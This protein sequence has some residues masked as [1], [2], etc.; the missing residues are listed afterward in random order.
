MAFK[1]NSKVD[2]SRFL[3]TYSF[4]FNTKITRKFSTQ[5]DAG[6]LYEVLARLNCPKTYEWGNSKN[7]I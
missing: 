5:W 7:L 2:L 3:T 1:P 6:T 4:H